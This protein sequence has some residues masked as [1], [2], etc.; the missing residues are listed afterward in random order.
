VLLWKVDA[1]NVTARALIWTRLVDKHSLDRGSLFQPRF[2][3]FTRWQF[4]AYYATACQLISS[5]LGDAE[6]AKSGANR[7]F[8]AFQELVSRY[9]QSGRIASSHNLLILYHLKNS[10]FTQAIKSYQQNKHSY[11][12]VRR[13]RE[14]RYYSRRAGYNNYIALCCKDSKIVSIVKSI[15]CF[16]SYFFAFL[17]KKKQSVSRWR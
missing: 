5:A 4:L 7:A 3:K 13:H 16:W 8:V 9:L 15:G 10:R 6:T 12:M 1:R 11:M 2:E 17:I 14:V